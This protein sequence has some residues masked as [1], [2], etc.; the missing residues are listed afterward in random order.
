MAR[1]PPK[2]CHHK[3]SD[4]GY[5]KFPRG[6]GT[7]E[8]VYFPGPY[9]S[10]ESIRAYADAV[11][12]H[13]N[14]RPVERPRRVSPPDRL[15]VAELVAAF[16]RHIEAHGLYRKGGRRTSEYHVLRSAFR[17]LATAYGAELAAAMTVAK[18]EAIRRTLIDCGK[19]DKTVKHYLQ[20]I[21]SLFAWGE[22][23]LGLLPVRLVSRRGLGSQRP[24]RGRLT[25]RK[26]P[27]DLA[28]VG[29]VALVAGPPVCSMLWLQHLNGMRPQGVCAMRPCDIDRTGELWV[30]TEPVED[31]AKTGRE[32]H[33][34]GPRAQAILRPYLDAA[35]SPTAPLF[36]PNR[37]PGAARGG[38][39]VAYYRRHVAGICKRLGVPRFSPNALRHGHLTRVRKLFGLDAARARGGHTTVTT[40]Q[41]YAQTDLDS[42]S[43][44]A[45]EIG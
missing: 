23:H 33:V 45:R 32:V 20:R 5:V 39:T 42:V 31:A 17:A 14:G 30:Y 18:V 25:P 16:F 40:T 9:N 21:R 28:A 2:Y 38:Y 13:R 10:P 35:T 4:R 15:T 11:D 24:P 12:R 1:K 19:A 37:R 8:T 22:E 3:P 26:R 41:I 43:E 27:A 7:Y 36:R 34:L 6:E 29:A 44:I